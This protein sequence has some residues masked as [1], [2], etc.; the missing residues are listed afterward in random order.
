MINY[1]M[2]HLQQ[3]INYLLWVF[4]NDISNYDSLT[5]KSLLVKSTPRTNGNTPVFAISIFIT[6][7]LT[8][9]FKQMII[10]ATELV[11]YQDNKTS[12]LI[13]RIEYRCQHD[14]HT[15]KFPLI[16]GKTMQVYT[17]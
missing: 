10:T 6:Q 1:L 9:G 3:T 5:L 14:I 15:S 7:F 13:L 16:S 11:S 12:S 17:V 8:Y 2:G 4:C